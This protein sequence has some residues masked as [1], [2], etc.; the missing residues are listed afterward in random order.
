ME[1]TI[2]DKIIIKR[3]IV[4]LCGPYYKK[5]N[6]ND[7]RNILRKTFE[8]YYDKDILPLIID[9]FLTKENLK[10][11]NINIQLLEELFAAISY[12]TYIFLDTMSAAS[13]LG[14]FM[15]HAYANHVTA[16]IPKESDILNKNNVGY[17]VKEI[18]LNDQK[19]ICI[20]YRP[21]IKRSAIATDY[22]VEH[23]EFINNIVP[24]NIENDIANDAYLKANQ[25]SPIILEKGDSFTNDAF[26]I[27][28]REHGG[29]V[30]VHTSLKLL[31]Y[32]T[33]SITYDFYKEILKTN[34]KINIK[35]FDLKLITD[36]VNEAYRNCIERREGLFLFDIKINTILQ[37]SLDEIIYHIVTFMYI[38]H[39]YSTYRGLRLILQYD[40]AIVEKVG[41]HPYKIFG[42]T[43]KDFE[44]LRDS[45]ANKNQYFTK[46]EIKSK[47][48]RRELIKY[49]DSEQGNTIRKI[50]EKMEESLTKRYTADP[51]SYAYKKGSSIKSCVEQHISGK[52]FLKYDIS[53]FFNSISLNELLKN[54]EEKFEI[55]EK[56]K[57]KTKAILESVFVENGLPLGLVLSPI[58]SDIYLNDLDVIMKEYAAKKGYVYTRYADDILI[59]KKQV[60]NEKEIIE[61]ESKLT[62]VLKQK[63][64]HLNEKKKRYVTLKESG[65]HMK[66]LGINIVFG[67]DENHLSVGRQYIYSV[68]KEYMQ[69]LEIEDEQDKFYQARRIAG[70]VGFIR[71]I[72]GE[73]GWNRLQ[74][75]LQYREEF[76]ENGHLKMESVK[77]F[78]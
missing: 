63:K 57:A 21:A 2:A 64:L 45:H 62:D 67:E 47:G 3:P 23:Y 4:F 46:L 60:F 8:K 26:K 56:Y 39:C 27:I 43:Q 18:V 58:L 75:R 15:N 76:F 73:N 50:H 70:K 78:L 29:C 34:S 25:Q 13:E 12:K 42:I 11:E 14:L 48:K 52:S 1:Y 53:K 16:Y 55:D 72:E 40:S 41:N 37:T 22:A 31:F 20:P 74:Q 35:D 51:V 19:A 10:D 36:K 28:Y 54:M 65:Q 9:D 5:D 69:Y 71:Q 59:S 38:Y 61:I 24:S 77:V 6:P 66:Y 49:S 30:T 32:V 17:F 33:A 68:A 44:I 7:R